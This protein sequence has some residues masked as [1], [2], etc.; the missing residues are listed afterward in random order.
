MAQPGN[1][2]PRN[3]LVNFLEFLRKAVNMLTDI[4]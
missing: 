3:F 2:D 1:L 4:V